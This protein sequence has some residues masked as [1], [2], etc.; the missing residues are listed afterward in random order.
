VRPIPTCLLHEGEQPHD[1]RVVDRSREPAGEPDGLGGEVDV[2]GA[3]L[4]EDQ[5]QDAQHGGDVAGPVEPHAGD[6][7]LGPAASEVTP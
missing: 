2:A 1:L 3:A 7:A 5:V 4:V 6:G